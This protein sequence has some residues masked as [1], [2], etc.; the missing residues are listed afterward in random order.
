MCENSNLISPNCYEALEPVTLT[1]GGFIEFK[2]SETH[3]RMQL[4]DTLYGGSTLWRLR[5]EVIKVKRFATTGSSLANLAGNQPPKKISLMFRTLRTSGLI[6]FAATNKDYTSLELVGGYLVYVSQLS[7]A[8]S[9]VNMTVNEKGLLSDNQW[10]NLTMISHNRGLRL[11]LDGD[12]VGEELDSAGVHD[13]LDPY[14]TDLFLGG[15]RRDT[16]RGGDTLPSGFSGCLAN[17]TVND[18]VQ[19][20]NGSGSIFWDSIQY[21]KVSPG[22]TGPVGIDTAASTTDPLSIGI[23]LVLVFFVILLVAILVS[24]VV[25]RLRKQKKE[26]SGG[27]GNHTKQNGGT[28][29][30]AGG[31]ANESGRTGLHPDSTVP[32]F[33]TDN[34]DVI[35]GVG[36]HHLVGPELISKRYKDSEVVGP[37]HQ[38]PQRPDIIEREVVGGKSPPPLPTAMHHS[39]EQP[40]VV[41]LDSELPEH[42]DLENASSIA[43]SDIDIVYHYK[44]YREGANL[45][46]YKP[47][48]P[49]LPGAPVHHKHQAAAAAAQQQ[50][51]HRH[52]PHHAA[53]A[54]GFPP[55]ARESPRPP[56]PV[57]R[58]DSP[59]KISLQHQSTPLARLS[60]SSELSQ[61]ITRILTL[62]DISGK[63]LQSALLATTSSS[64]GV[65]KDVLHSNSERSLN[66]PVMSR[67]SG[68][69]SSASRKTPNAGQDVGN[70]GIPIG[71][72]AEEIDRLNVRPRTSSL[73]STLDAVSSSSGRGVNQSGREPHRLHHGAVNGGGDHSST[74]TDESG[75]DSFTCSEIE[76]DNNSVTGEKL[77]DVIFTKLSSPD[78]ERSSR[79]RNSDTGTPDNKPPPPPTSYD[80]FDSSFRGSLSTL[81]PS[82]DDL[83]HVGGPLYRP[84]NGSPSSLPAADSWN[85]LLDWGP[86]F[87]S[88]VGVFNDIAE[89]PDSVNAR[90]PPSSLRLPNGTSKPSEE[91]V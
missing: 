74:T 69:S 76:Y 45:R 23:S 39:H 34:G 83:S 71:L 14:L 81:V 19:P 2:I 91:Y 79:T 46:K 65:G 80:G 86:D 13:F 30:V 90:G 88:L 77:S 50:Q 58:V 59:N 55:H 62:Q 49:H 24:F 64:G 42:Y 20:M 16:I 29:L 57:S 11:M 67:L 72:T 89:L 8:G 87:E 35:R 52:S 32:S 78:D 18:E 27:G 82:D 41:G 48:P 73:V 26:K 38:R 75:N 6:F 47:T 25:F 44:G 54:A 17:F 68:Q 1:D 9:P 36:G 37:E 53:A 56:P 43:P 63:P 15:V 10:H 84:Q 51:Q 21:G 85:Y 7:S 61:G 4:L 22:C 3:R 60:P 66:S 28:T 70:G 33:M 12:R 40:A 31:L 5:N